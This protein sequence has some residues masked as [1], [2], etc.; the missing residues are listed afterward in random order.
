MKNISR[1][2]FLY[3]F[4]LLSIVLNIVLAIKLYNFNSTKNI[5]EGTKNSNVV[6]DN[7][8]AYK[9]NPID[10]YV[11]KELEKDNLTYAE[12]RNIKR[13]YGIL[14]KEEYGSVIDFLIEKYGNEGKIKDIDKEIENYVEKMAKVVEIIYYD[15]DEA[16]EEKNLGL[17]D[18]ANMQFAKGRIYRDV[19]MFLVTNLVDDYTFSEKDY[20]KIV[21]P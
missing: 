13:L 15:T 1:K 8:D 16:S 11:D 10:K 21:I 2:V 9:D 7:K 12:I 17:S 6:K 20:E 4:V 19:C 5:Y 18:W 14:W 3:A